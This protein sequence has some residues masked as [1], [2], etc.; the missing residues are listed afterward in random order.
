MGFHHL[1][2]QG[3]SL[4]NEVSPKGMGTLKACLEFSTLVFF[5]KTVGLIYVKL[6]GA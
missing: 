4:L 6:F 5:S 1:E 3:L 2:E